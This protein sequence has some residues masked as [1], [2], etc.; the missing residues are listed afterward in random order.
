[1]G[2]ITKQ[3][4][5]GTPPTVTNGLVLHLDAGSRQS[6]VSGSTTWNDLSGNRNNGTLTVSGSGAVSAS[7]SS[8]NQGIIRNSGS[9]A[10][11]SY[12]EVLDNSTLDFG[13]GSFT[14]EYWFRKLATTSAYSN[15][16]G[17]NK[18]NTGATPGSNEWLLVI[19]NSSTGN[20]NTISFGIESGSCF[21]TTPDNTVTI[22]LNTW[23]QLVGLRNGASLQTY[24]NGNIVQNIISPIGSTGATLTANSVVNNVVGLNLRINN[25]AL[26]SYFTN[27][28][29]AVVKV[30]NRALSPAEVT[31][32]YNALKNRFGLF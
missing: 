11:G 29:N 30:Y 6:Y 28:D 21:F 25:S 7:F 12:V 31:Q 16:W 22:S 32:N 14:V 13:S 17:V 9:S 24:L 5:F 20:G 23:Y 8:L 19:G 18:W 4:Y 26:N 1:M 3:G 10:V 27:A 2:T 15:I